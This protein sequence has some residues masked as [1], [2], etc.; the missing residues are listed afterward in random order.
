MLDNLEMLLLEGDR[1]GN[2]LPGYEGYGRLLQRLAETAHQSCVLVTSREKPKEI[3]P[4]EGSR[5]PVRSLRLVGLDEQTAQALLSDKGLVGEKDSWQQLI[6]TVQAHDGWVRSIRVSP[7][8][9][10]AA[11]CGEDGAIKLWDIRSRQH[12]STIRSNRPYERLTIT[13]V[14]GLTQAQKV[15]LRALGAVE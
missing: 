2:Y 8:G 6:A 9:R 5:S 12:I 15:T 13:G 1:E 11:S 14:T 7:D 10:M 4:L 3:G